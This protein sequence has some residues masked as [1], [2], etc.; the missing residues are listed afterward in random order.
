MEGNAAKRETKF[1][2]KESRRERIRQL[3]AQEHIATQMELSHRLEEEGFQ[4]TQATVSRDIRELKLVKRSDG[5]GSYYYE[6]SE[7]VEKYHAPSKFYAM[8]QSAVTQVDYAQ[9]L[10]VIHTYTGMAQAV[11]ATMDSVEWPGVLGTIAG[12]DTVLVITRTE[13]T[14]KSLVDTLSQIG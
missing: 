10:V 3:I 6:N 12:D 5:S 9:N 13:A 1:R 8:F 11:C 14:A 2:D 4:V 7:P